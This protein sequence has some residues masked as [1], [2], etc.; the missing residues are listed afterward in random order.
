MGN[1]IDLNMIKDKKSFIKS[2]EKNEELIQ[3]ILHNILDH[4][5]VE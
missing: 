3:F 2:V 4:F 5:G 1:K